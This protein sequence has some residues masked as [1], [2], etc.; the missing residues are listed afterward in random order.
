MNYANFKP[1]DRISDLSILHNF[2]KAWHSHGIYES[3]AMQLLHDF[4]KDSANAALAHRVYIIKKDYLQ[5][6][7]KLT[8]YYQAVN[9][10]LPTHKTNVSIAKAKADMSN[11]R[12]LGGISAIC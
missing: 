10:L 6:K 3:T 2:K 4:L 12:Q 7:G 1:S 9:D 8:T 11:Y 5:Q